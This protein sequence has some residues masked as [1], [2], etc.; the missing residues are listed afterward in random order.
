MIIDSIHLP[1]QEY[2]SSAPQWLSKTSIKDYQEHGP[3]WWKQ[4]YLDRTLPRKRPDGASQGLA[5]DCWL[6]E[7][8]G[9][10][11]ALYA[12]KPEDMS[13]ATKEG[14]AWKAEQ[15]NRE[16]ITSD[17]YAILIEAVDAVRMHP[18]WKNIEKCKAQ[19]TIRRKSEGLG[20]G[21]QSRPD[22][23]NV[24]A[25]TVYD[26]K[27]TRDLDL[28]SKQAVGLGYVLQNAIAGW[29]LAG[30]GIG[31]EHAYLVA[32][33]WKRGARCRVFKIPDEAMA[34]ADQSMRAGASEIADRLKRNDWVDHPPEYETLALTTWQMEKVGAA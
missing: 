34:A 22:W 3:V 29:C 33:E 9:V 2:H 6:T 16:I 12:I 25:L 5:L 7:G 17:D 27:K 30:L 20:I 23:L 4:A 14:K 15:G 19:Q 18:Q 28:F 10:F 24:D 21:L 31:L 11:R 1:I 13:F 8:E 32:V 26:L